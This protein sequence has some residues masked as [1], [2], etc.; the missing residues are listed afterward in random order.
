MKAKNILLIDDNDVD[1]Y[2]TSYTLEKSEMAENIIIHTSAN[3][4]LKFLDEV[5]NEPDRIP[6]YI[7]LDI[8]MPE[9]DGFGFLEEYALFPTTIRN[10]CTIFMLTSS[11]DQK[12]MARATQYPYVKKF[13]IKPFDPDMLNEL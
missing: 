6:E 7:F 2:I 9:M 11:S 12:D 8:R 10:R 3:D 4:A 5:Q 13:L 1:N